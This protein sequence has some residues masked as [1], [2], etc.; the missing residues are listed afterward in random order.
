M[1][2]SKDNILALFPDN[3]NREITAADIRRFVN[4]VFDEEVDIT[5]IEDNL[6]STVTDVPLSANQGRILDERITSEIA[7]LGAAKEDS[8]GIGQDGW[9]LVTR[10]DGFGTLNKVWESVF[11][12]SEV[13]VY[14]YLDST[15]IVDALSANQGR[16]LN[17]AITSH[18]SS[19]SA[20]II[21]IAQNTADI[22]QNT[23]DILANTNGLFSLGNRVTVNEGDIDTLTISVNQINV[24]L[25]GKEDIL[26][27]PAADGYL[28]S[29]TALGA[30]SWVSRGSVLGVV[31]TLVSTDSTAP[32]SA[33]MGRELQDT[34]EADLGVPAVDS[35]VLSSDIAGTRAWVKLEDITLDFGC[36][37]AAG[38][39]VPCP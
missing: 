35:S 37:D 24:D 13:I 6:I 12:P 39:I 33:N 25:N 15:S 31:D 11:I 7:T 19:I 5:D 1:A 16:V 21:N 30:R 34:K 20:N 38:N 23:I 32:L 27:N 10:D 8:L 18:T 4:A 2:N 29:S 22:A 17:N 26:G 3:N 28:L 36:Y 14:D 9:F